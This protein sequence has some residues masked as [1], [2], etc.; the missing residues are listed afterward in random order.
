MW[1]KIKLPKLWVLWLMFND[2]TRLSKIRNRFMREVLR[3]VCKANKL[4]KDKIDWDG[5]G[6]L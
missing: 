4:M 3:V 1:I 2:M 6:M 5:M